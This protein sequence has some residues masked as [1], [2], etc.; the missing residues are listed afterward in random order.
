MIF[1]RGLGSFIILLTFVS[2][3]QAR[4]LGTFGATYPIVEKDAL[5]EI[6]EKARTTD[7]S[8]AFSREMWEKKLKAY[9]PSELKP[10]PRAKRERVFLLD[11]TYSLDFDIPDGKGGILYPKGYTFNPLDYVSY[12]NTLVFID[13]SDP[14]QVGWLI[15]SEYS[16]DGSAMI[17]ITAGSYYDLFARLKRPVFYADARIVEKFRLSAVPAVVHQK[18]NV[19]EVREIAVQN[20]SK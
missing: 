8:R 3:V 2:S 15:S 20:T 4:H 5:E 12:P 19:F 14:I 16:T 10:L 11:L 7:W 17:L 13:G 1:T 18:E 9:R 6:Q